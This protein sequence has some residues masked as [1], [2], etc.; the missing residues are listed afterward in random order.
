M[1][2][3]GFIP[4]QAKS[5]V[6]EAMTQLNAVLMRKN[7]RSAFDGPE[8]CKLFTVLLSYFLP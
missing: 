7:H 5:A 3:K 6:H 4:R 8:V 1:R 2:N